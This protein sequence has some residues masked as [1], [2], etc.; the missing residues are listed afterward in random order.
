M[1]LYKAELFQRLKGP[2][3][4]WTRGYVVCVLAPIV[5]LVH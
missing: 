3:Q 4:Y 5:I 1:S 2:V